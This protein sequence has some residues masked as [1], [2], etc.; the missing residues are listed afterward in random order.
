MP[1]QPQI[2]SEP[3]EIYRLVRH[4]QKS[5]RRVGVVPTMGAL[6]EGHLSLVEASRAEC[7]VTIVT[8]FVNPTQFGPG[9]D[10]DLYPR[11]L[12]Q[13][14][15][16]L[17]EVGAD[18]V[19]V[20]AGDAIY[21]PGHSTHIDPPVVAQP[22][23][24]ECRPGHFRGVATIVLKLFQMIPVDVAFFGQKDYQQSLVI[25]RMVD[26]LNVP[27]EICICPT[28]RETDGLAMSSRNAYLS[29]QERRQALAISQALEQATAMRDSGEKS[30][31]S[32]LANMRRI[33]ADANILRVDYVALVDPNTLE[34][35][36]HLHEA[37]VALIAAYVGSTRLIDNK[38]L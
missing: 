24:G 27:I 26:D 25:Q 37:T 28:V 34:E 2:F 10:F 31:S 21:R 38:L 13:D 1:Q 8:I 14:V 20:P 11:T 23:E 4:A 17:A 35:R 36:E 30:A 18:Y 19:F 22:L 3:S 5:G 29:A 6:H 15:N 32:V 7:D 12:E 9:E 16:K 33:L